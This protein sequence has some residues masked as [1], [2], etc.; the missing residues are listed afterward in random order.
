MATVRSSW[1][2]SASDGAK[3]LGLP[4]GVPESSEEDDVTPATGCTARGRGRGRG[5][6]DT[7]VAAA[8]NAVH[9]G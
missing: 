3:E 6:T 8:V 2:T 4:T 1:R 9:F 5:L 7:G